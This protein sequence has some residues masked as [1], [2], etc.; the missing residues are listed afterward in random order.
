M[1]EEAAYYYLGEPSPSGQVPAQPV[2]PERLTRIADLPAELMSAAVALVSSS[3]QYALNRD[4]NY[5]QLAAGQAIVDLLAEVA[6]LTASRNYSRDIINDMTQEARDLE[7]AL[8]A[9]EAERDEARGRVARL[10]AEVVAGAKPADTDWQSVH[11]DPKFGE[12][13]RGMN[14][15]REPFLRWVRWKAHEIGLAWPLPEAFFGYDHTN[16][17]GTLGQYAAPEA[18]AAGEAGQEGGVQDG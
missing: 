1:S 11:N 7:A 10:L 4:L 13:L 5:A 6:G 15:G 18:Q 14:A 17:D 12:F 8:A 16:E 3:E 9:A 2:T